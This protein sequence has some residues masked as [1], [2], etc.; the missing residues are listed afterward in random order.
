MPTTCGFHPCHNITLNKAVSANLLGQPV[1]PVLSIGAETRNSSFPLPSIQHA[2]NLSLDTSIPIT[3]RL[4]SF[5]SIVCV[6]TIPP[7]LSI[8]EMQV[9]PPNQSSTVTRAYMAQ[10]TNYGLGRQGTDLGQG[11]QTQGEL[12]SPAFP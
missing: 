3:A 7:P 8:A 6:I 2:S 1:K 11:L 12:R 9:S 5:S 10:S 4:C